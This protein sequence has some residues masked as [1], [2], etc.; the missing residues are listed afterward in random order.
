MPDDVLGKDWFE[1]ADARRRRWS[2]SVWIPLRQAEWL[3]QRGEDHQ[4]GFIGEFLA[5][6]SIAFPPKNRELAE[7]LGWTDL[8]LMHTPRPFAFD[9]GRYKPADVYQYHDGEDTGIHLV[10]INELVGHPSEW[11]VNQDLILA[12]GL[13]QENDSW[14]MPS[15]GYIEVMRQR[16]DTEGV[17]KAIEIKAEFLRDYLAARGL[18]LRIG[19]YRQRSAILEDASALPDWDKEPIRDRREHDRFEARKYAVSVD[20]G[21]PGTI[22]VMRVWRTDVDATADVP[23]MGPETDQNTESSFHT[24]ERKSATHWRIEGE[25]WREEWLEPAPRSERIRRDQSLED[26]H[27]TV[28]A[29]GT[30]A[31]ASQLNDEDIGK[32]LWFRPSVIPALLDIRGSGLHWYTEQTGAIE[33]SPGWPTHFGVNPIGLIN[34]YAYDIAK[35]PPWLQRHWAGHNIAPDGSVSRELLDAQARGE[36]ADTVAPEEEFVRLRAEVDVA[37]LKW[38]GVPLFQD[39]RFTNEILRKIHRFRAQDEQSLLALAKDIARV[40]VDMIVQEPLKK[41]IEQPKGEKWGG[42][43][44]LQKAL[45]EVAGP[46]RAKEALTPLVGV[47]D[48]RLGDAH[49][50]SGELADGYKLVGVDE[51]ANFIEQ[52]MQMIEGANR[53]L[54]NIISIISDH[55]KAG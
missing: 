37:V 5:T 55:L 12:F 34:V 35:L 13:L 51:N 1:M 28:G 10:V 49:P 18:A 41:I 54:S 30:R 46:Q 7:K 8:G 27:Y 25:L 6:G 17:T 38:L 47:Y 2:N 52:G 21:V 48:L 26:I 36:P 44:H 32:W 15:E 53:S 43:T 50:P 19:T 40:T 22:A 3:S 23:V 31:P 29:D 33:A 11:M 16:R 24:Y 42:R 4:L 45:A 14:V 39:H 20:G 9:D